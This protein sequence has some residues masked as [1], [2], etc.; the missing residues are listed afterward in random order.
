MN[1]ELK[2]LAL[3]KAEK[4]AKEAVDFAFELLEV[5]VKHSENKVDDAFFAS[6]KD[7]AAEA[8]KELADKIH[9]E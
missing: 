7:L 2:K 6:L 9:V 5:V 4:E 3:K 1:E 8:L